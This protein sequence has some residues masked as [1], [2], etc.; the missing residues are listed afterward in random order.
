MGFEA[1]LNLILLLQ[2]PGLKILAL[3]ADAGIKWSAKTASPKDDE[4]WNAVKLV[5]LELQGATPEAINSVKQ[6][7]QGLKDAGIVGGK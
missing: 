6:I 3:I 7:I 2:G 5:A 4:F 1:I